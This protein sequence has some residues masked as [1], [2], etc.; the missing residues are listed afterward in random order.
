MHILYDHQMF[1]IQ[2][3]GGISRIFIELMRELSPLDGCAVHWH[4][5]VKTDGY[6]ISSFRPHLKRYWGLESLPF[7]LA[8]CHPKTI[9]QVTFKAFNW[10]FPKPYDI[11]HPSYYDADILE[12]VSAK[13]LVVTICDMIPE[14]LLSHE[15]K[16]QRFI[17]GKRQ[18]V[19][20][21]DLIF[22]ISES[23]KRDLIE[24]LQAPAEKVKVTH[25]ASRMGAVS[26]ASILP[27]LVTQKPYFLY[28]GTRSRYKNF[29][30]LMRAFAT[31]DW[32]RKNFQVICFGGS[33]QFLEPELAFLNQHGLQDIF[34]YLKGDDGLLKRL[35]QQAMAL[36][37]TSRYEG[38]GLPPLEA[39]ECGCPVICCPTSSL[40]EVVDNAG[41]W[42]QPDAVEEL[43]KGMKLL[44]TDT[45]YRESAV[46]KGLARAQAFSWRQTAAQTL[47]GYRAVSA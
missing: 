14:K 5:G 22:A 20:R 6:D 43:V 23:T 4:R 27:S 32:L 8:K 3:F 25:L 17:E 39:M 46:Q 2:R 18:L 37:Y 21:A 47:M 13:H 7:E 9:N 24:L 38:F 29:G 1:A 36:V 28:V 45:A 19:Q 26:A 33:S 41:T 35:Y 30:I 42:F 16:F 12:A 44:A 31:D 11:Y 10:L 40:P 15:T 34:H